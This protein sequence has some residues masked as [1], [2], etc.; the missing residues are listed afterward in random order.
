MS[1]ESI[2]RL[3]GAV[4]ESAGGRCA[5]FAGEDGTYQYAVSQPGGDLRALAK[6]INTALNGRGGGK[7]EFIQGSV[8]H[9]GAAGAGLTPSPAG[10]RVREI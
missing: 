7:P 10:W 1:A 6:E 5:V 9:P 4:Q 8:G 3:C 2:R